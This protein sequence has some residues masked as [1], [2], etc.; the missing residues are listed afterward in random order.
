[1]DQ[2]PSTLHADILASLQRKHT[3][4][5]QWATHNE[6]AGVNGT[7]GSAWPQPGS[8]GPTHPRS[9][10]RQQQQHGSAPAAAAA[11]SNAPAVKS[12]W[13]E[14]TPEL[15][16]GGGGMDPM[17]MSDQ[18]GVTPTGLTAHGSAPAGLPGLIGNEGMAGEDAVGMVPEP[19][20]LAHGML[21]AGAAGDMGADADDALVITTAPGSHANVMNSPRLLMMRHP[22]L[23]Q[24]PS[25][26]K[27]PFSLDPHHGGSNAG[28]LIV[29]PMLQ[30]GHCF[31]V[32][33]MPAGTVTSG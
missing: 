7:Q 11:G 31:Q 25:P 4:Q 23:G 29:I 8:G 28:M 26:A 22:S 3:C 20:P 32:C 30:V 18:G 5:I 2:L 16:L 17:G 14:E 19:L 15:I 33:Q 24:G 6:V 10:A 21:G 1:M 12:E 9:A 27:H 13:R